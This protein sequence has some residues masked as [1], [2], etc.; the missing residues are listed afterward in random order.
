MQH[1][2]P[3]A[4]VVRES[5]KSFEQLC[6]DLEASVRRHSYGVLHQGNTGDTL[7][8]KGIAFTEQ[9]KQFDICNPQVASRVLSTDMR[10]GMVMPCRMTVWTNQ[11][12]THIGMVPP[13]AMLALIS[14][15]TALTQVASAVDA[16]LQAI[17]DDAV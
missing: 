4:A 6:S 16:D 10:L 14:H 9:V 7:R 2:A 5:N 3:T 12:K 11:G 1:S 13:T 17:L 15:D 8:S